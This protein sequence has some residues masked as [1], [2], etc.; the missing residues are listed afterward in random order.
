LVGPPPDLKA[1]HDLCT[2]VP[3]VNKLLV[4]HRLVAKLHRS[5]GLENVTLYITKLRNPTQ[6]ATM[7]TALDLG[8][9]QRS[10]EKVLQSTK[11]RIL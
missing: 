3:S 10:E 6:V 9:F 8:V 5:P 11:G 4:G 7:T 1:Q 2:R